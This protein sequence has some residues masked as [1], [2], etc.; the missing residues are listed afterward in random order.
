MS[1]EYLLTFA[2]KLS[3]LQDNNLK[4]SEWICKNTTLDNKPFSFKGH[5]FQTGIADDKE[6]TVVIQKCCQIGLTELHCRSAIEL[7]ANRGLTVIF[8]QPNFMMAKGFSKSRISPI[9]ETSPKLKGMLKD[10]NSVDLKQLGEGFLYVR[11]TAGAESHALSIPADAILVDELDH[12]DPKNVQLFRSRLEHSKHRIE[13]FFGTPTIPKKGIP[14][15]IK[16]TNKKHYQ[17]KCPHCGEWNF[18]DINNLINFP[19]GIFEQGEPEF[20]Q[21][22]N[23]MLFSFEDKCYI[24]CKR[25]G[26]SFESSNELLIPE[27]SNK[28]TS[29]APIREWVWENENRVQGAGTGYLLNQLATGLKTGRMIVQSMRGYFDMRDIYNQILGLPFAS[30]VDRLVD[31][32]IRFN[33]LYD[34]E[35]PYTV[36]GLDFG[37]ICNLIILYYDYTEKEYIIVK[38]YELPLVTLDNEEAIIDSLI[39]LARK[40]NSVCLAM[41]SQPYPATVEKIKKKMVIPSIDV[42]LAD[43]YDKSMFNGDEMRYKYN[44]TA[45]I[46]NM[47]SDFKTGRT[48]ITK[49]CLPDKQ[50]LIQHFTN[51]IKDVNKKTGTFYYP[52]LSGD[53]HYGFAYMYAKIAQ[54]CIDEYSDAFTHKGVDFVPFAL[55]KTTL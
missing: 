35:P 29:I 43:R 14:E 34:I 28:I 33:N 25:C 1:N 5:E 18:M 16:N 40:H 27:T 10:T 52:K 8:T 51:F 23:D 39:Q 9:I 7:V 17:V 26:G 31:E 6:R 42:Y 13:R 15:M 24:G 37:K 4:P 49:A 50:V 36:M 48:T 38:N 12:S 47:L 22:Y 21:L 3:S 54:K 2:A 44:R 11:Y 53:D 45:S 41:D 20:P 19:H 46:D 32:D 55:G 30:S